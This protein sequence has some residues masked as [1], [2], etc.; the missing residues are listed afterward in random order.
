MAMSVLVDFFMVRLA[1]PSAI[2]RPD[3]SPF[4][5]VV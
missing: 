4:D 5:A 2:K 1:F 3:R